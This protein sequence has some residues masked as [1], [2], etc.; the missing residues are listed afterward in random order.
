M[1][2]VDLSVCRFVFALGADPLCARPHLTG[3][4]GARDGL[5][6][7]ID[8]D[9][10]RVLRGKTTG[11]VRTA[12]SCNPYGVPYCSCKLTRG[13]TARR[14]LLCAGGAGGESASAVVL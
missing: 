3:A 9:I 7:S 2:R 5:H 11:E 1:T 12:Y 10:E 6:N 8:A 13:V 4:G 14:G